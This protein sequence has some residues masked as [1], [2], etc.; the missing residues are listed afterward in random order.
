MSVSSNSVCSSV[1]ARLSEMREQAAIQKESAALLEERAALLEKQRLEDLRQSVER[2]VATSSDLWQAEMLFAAE[3]TQRLLEFV[4]TLPDSYKPPP[5]PRSREPTLYNETV[6]VRGLL[7]AIYHGLKEPEGPCGLIVA[8]ERARYRIRAMTSVY[9]TLQATIREEARV[10]AEKVATERAVAAAA[11]KEAQRVKMNAMARAHISP[12][13]PMHNFTDSGGDPTLFAVYTPEHRL[14][15]FS[16]GWAGVESL[17]QPGGL[18]DFSCAGA[19]APTPFQVPASWASHYAESK[20][21]F[22]PACPT[23]GKATFVHS[24]TSVAPNASHVECAEHYKWEADANRHFKWEKCPPPVAPPGWN[25]NLLGQVYHTPHGPPP[26]TGRWIP[27]DPKDPEGA[28]AAKAV[29]DR[30]IAE[31]SAEIARLQA[32]LAELL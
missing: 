12:A 10:A 25:P 15:V 28:F 14:R 19:T 27:W 11:H 16:V 22:L 26:P 1:Q 21:P 32:R 18:S 2:E 31:A 5:P 13:A 29:K 9:N 20:L 3:T 8:N 30:Q 4:R 24:S 17:L 7:S 23:C 6:N